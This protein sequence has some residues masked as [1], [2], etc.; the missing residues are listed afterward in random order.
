M[1]DWSRVNLTLLVIMA[2]MFS[3]DK[4]VKTELSK[5]KC[6]CLPGVRRDGIRAARVKST[7]FACYADVT[8]C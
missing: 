4:P 3:S 2:V 8:S 5:T 6:Y 7:M 1:T